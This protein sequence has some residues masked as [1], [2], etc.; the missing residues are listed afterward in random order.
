MLL[1]LVA[2][3]SDPPPPATLRHPVRVALSWYPAPEFG[4]FYE[5][6]LSGAYEAAGL[7]VTLIPGGPG[8]PVIELLEG[9][10]ADVAIS[11]ADDLLLRRARGLQAVAILPGFQDSPVGLMV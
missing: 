11:G 4:G 2:C 5:A 7:E 9:G 8:N 1:L 10:S 3:S 6:V